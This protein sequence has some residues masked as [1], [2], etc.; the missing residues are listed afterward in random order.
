MI[1]LLL[2]CFYFALLLFISH[3]PAV[4][5]GDKSEELSFQ[6]SPLSDS[7]LS[8][9]TGREGIAL[10]LELRVNT[11][12]NGKPLQSLSYCSGNNNPC[13]IAFNFLNR[14]S[15]AVGQKGEWIVWKDYYG[16]TRINNLWIDAGQNP[17]TASTYQDTR[18]EALGNRFMSGSGSCLL[19]SSKTAATCYQGALN[20]PALM[21]TFNNGQAGGLE[22]FMNLGRVSTE[23]GPTAFNSDARGTSLGVLIGD[24]SGPY[25]PARFKIGGR[26]GL[27]GF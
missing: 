3:G 1:K 11:D 26:V 22:L 2:S 12:A 21:M 20:K 15:G 8:D 24:T 27:Y 9:V 18:S 13:R 5:A 17:A 6:I 19:D 16:L 23:Y 10:D 14:E 25:A 7:D 4:M